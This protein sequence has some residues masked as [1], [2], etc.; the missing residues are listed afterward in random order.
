MSGTG[1]GDALTVQEVLEHE[2]ML[3]V[4]YRASTHHTA[5]VKSP[6]DADFDDLVQE[7][8]VAAWRAIQSPRS[9][10]QTYGAV[11]A[12]NR[13]NGM[14]TGR[15]P[16]TGNEAEPGRRIHDQARQTAQREDMAV[17]EDLLDRGN[18]YVAVEQ[19]V[20][21]DRALATLD[22]RDQAVARLV[23]LDQPW[24]VI[25]PAVGMAPLGARTRWTKYVRPA[26]RD[27]LEAAA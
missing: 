8:A 18:P 10:P 3:R 5:K 25:G 15:Y 11:S 26:L 1:F 27:A 24:D 19:R 21:M 16:M 12:R 20:D 14:H 17:T 22:L 2:E 6:A 13:I 9:D 7:G 23:A 4:F